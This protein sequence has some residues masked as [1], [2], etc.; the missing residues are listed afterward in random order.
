MKTYTIK[1][2]HH[3]STHLPKLLFGN[4]ILSST[5]K[6]HKDCWFPLNTSD[7]YAINKLV[8]WSNG[9]HHRNSI[10][11]GWR[12]AAVPGFIDLFFYIYNKGHRKEAF[13]TTV[14]CDKEFNLLMAY[15][16]GKILFSIEEK[17][18]IVKVDYSGPRLGYML[19]P[20]FGGQNTAPH[21][22][23]IDLEIE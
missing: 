17:M 6:F 3:Y 1:K 14:E 22:I 9:L 11:C 16:G 15:Q 5:V 21:D 23:N 8:G 13:F 12:P 10:R 19:F 18:I 7:D 4:S 20:Y 2:G